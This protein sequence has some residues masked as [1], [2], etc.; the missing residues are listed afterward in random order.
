[1]FRFDFSKEFLRRALSSPGYFKTWH[2]AV[3]VTS[4]KIL[5]CFIS[6]VPARI[7]IRGDVVNMAEVNFLCCHKKLMV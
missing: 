4:P 7:R 2:F 5:V 6:G 1:M 3:R